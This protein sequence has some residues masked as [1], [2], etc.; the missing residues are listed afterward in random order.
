MKNKIEIAPAFKELWTDTKRRFFIYWGGRYGGKN[1]HIAPRLAVSSLESRKQILVLREFGKSSAGA[2]Y[3][4]IKEFFKRND[5]ETT[6]SQITLG[7]SEGVT[8]RADKIL[9]NITGSE[10]IFAGV[11]DRTV[12]SLKGY[13]RADW[14]WVDEANFISELAFNKLNHTVRRENSKLVF[15]FNPEKSSDFIYKKA[16][17]GTD[18]FT[19]VRK[20]TAAKY[21]EASGEWIKGDNPFLNETILKNINYDYKTLTPRLFAYNHLGVPFDNADDCLFSDG[22]F[23]QM[24]DCKLWERSDYVSVV[25]GCDPAATSKDY[26]NQFGIAVVGLTPKGEFHCLG[27]YT[28]NHTPHSF[29][30]KVNELYESFKADCVVV[31]TNQ[32]GDFL[33]STL[34]VTNP[35]MNVVEVRA[36][37]D[38]MTRALPVANLAGLG[39][40]KIFDYGREQLFEQMRATTTKGYDGVRGS[41]PDALDAFCWAVFHLGNLRKKEQ[42]N[43][44]FDTD[45]F[46][47]ERSEFAFPA[48]VR[49]IFAFISTSEACYFEFQR[50]DNSEV[51]GCLKFTRCEVLPLRQFIQSIGDIA[52][53]CDLFLP[54]TE[55]ALNID[56]GGS[57]YE[58]HTGELDK[59]AKQVL[60][61]IPQVVLD[62]S[63]VKP[64]F[65]SNFHGNVLERELRAFKFDTQSDNIVLRCFFELILNIAG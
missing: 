2:S 48:G 54:Y 18:D 49:T 22:A 59:V 51:R 12:S 24:S 53:E 39:L 52:S 60:P 20:V 34:L 6:L 19:L 26:S 9:V 33:K 38:K 7:E 46:I 47:K 28:S 16:L 63:A 5:I 31:E 25:V 65:N 40:I 56:I 57:F 13:N 55:T 36:T 32:G 45:I 14:V 15:S 17:L 1:G 64:S 29:A 11:N 62:I 10:F 58:T 42:E 50:F 35:L 4:D 23:T 43:S 61:L 41:S 27:N 8:Y 3:D 30:E 37:K 44:V 21:D